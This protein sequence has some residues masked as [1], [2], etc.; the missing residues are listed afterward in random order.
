MYTDAHTNQMP[1]TQHSGHLFYILYLP[2]K[3]FSFFFSEAF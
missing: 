1:R 2:V 3:V